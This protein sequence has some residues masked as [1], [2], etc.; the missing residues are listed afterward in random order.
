MSRAS[1]EVVLLGKPG[2]HLCEAVE[3]EVRSLGAAVSRLIVVNI[4]TDRVLYDK[5]QLRIPIITVGGKVVF[6]AS[7]M[8]PEGEWKDR[9]SQLL[10]HTRHRLP[11]AT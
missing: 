11:S 5:Y 7:M 6:E 3:T 4:D 8:D 9:L 2:C 1:P 10:G